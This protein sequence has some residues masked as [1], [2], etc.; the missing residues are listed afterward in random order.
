MLCVLG[1]GALGGL[2]AALLAEGGADVALLVPTAERA[3]ALREGLRLSGPGARPERVVRV[4]ALGPDDAPAR[5]VEAALL[6]VKARDTAPAVARA[7]A[8]PG[9]PTLVVLQ[10]GLGR[11]EEVARLLGDADRVVSAVTSQGATLEQDGRLRHAGRGPTRLG[12][13]TPGG[14]ARAEAAARA[15]AAAGLEAEVVDDPARLVWEK[16]QVNAAINALTGLLGCANGR[17]LEAPSARSLAGEAAAEVGAVARSLGVTGDWSAAA[18]RDRWEAVARATA[19]NASSTLQDLRRG[20][21]TEVNAING[22][23]AAA[24]REAGVAA[25]IN[26]LLARL[27]AAAEELTAQ[28]RGQGRARE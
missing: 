5:P 2:L 8:L 28:G 24:A 23:V 18:A 4:A 11:A 12:A 6:C 21:P 17:L 15:L 10:N 19:D 27:V 7:A 13:L 25:P 3:A 26:E 22:A 14:R 16:L 1:P 20:R 9:G